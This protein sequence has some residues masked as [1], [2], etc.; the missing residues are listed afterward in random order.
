M[1][2][3]RWIAIGATAAT[4][5]WAQPAAAHIG[6]PDVFL[7]GRAGPYRLLVTVRAY[8]RRRLDD[9]GDDARVV[10]A[11]GHHF[12]DRYGPERQSAWTAEAMTAVGAHAYHFA[13]LAAL[14]EFGPQSQAR[15]GQRC[16]IGT[17]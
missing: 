12:L 4:V 9:L 3:R 14:D 15:I 16:G 10:G 1:P 8:A 7:D 13:I 11:L 2:R 6:S 5:L 17:A